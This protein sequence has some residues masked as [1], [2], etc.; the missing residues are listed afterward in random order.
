VRHIENALWAK[1]AFSDFMISRGIKIADMSLDGYVALFVDEIADEQLDRLEHILARLAAQYGYRYE[2]PVLFDESKK[3]IIS[4]PLQF[5][6]L[7]VQQLKRMGMDPFSI[8][9][10]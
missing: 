1:V 9:Y 2:A 3:L 4:E 7:Y 6:K 10:I 8:S 5:I